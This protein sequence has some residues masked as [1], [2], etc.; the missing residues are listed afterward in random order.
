MHYTQNRNL[1]TQSN[2]RPF[3][4]SLTF[5][6]AELSVVGIIVKTKAQEFQ[7]SDI[8]PNALRPVYIEQSDS[9]YSK[10]V[11][12]AQLDQQISLFQ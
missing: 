1:K 5:S 2:Q 8:D 6:I 12:V 9:C 11:L 10:H 3:D 4:H 7:N